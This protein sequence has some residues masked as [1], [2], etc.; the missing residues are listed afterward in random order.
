ML[1]ELQKICLDDLSVFFMLD[2]LIAIS[3]ETAISFY[4]ATQCSKISTILTSWCVMLKCG[5]RMGRM[6]S[7]TVRR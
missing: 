5:E 7:M 4:G 2:E 1:S 6:P 3:A